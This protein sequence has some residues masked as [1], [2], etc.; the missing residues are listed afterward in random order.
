MTAISVLIPTF[1]YVCVDLVRSL[2]QQLQR[3]DADYE[4]I[5]ADDGSTNHD[6]VV[7]NRAIHGMEHC[8]YV[9]RQQ[10][11]GR[12]AIRNFLASESQFPL[13]LF[14]DSDMVVTRDDFMEAYLKE[15]DAQVVD[16]GVQIRG[17]EQRNKHNLRFIYEKKS[18]ELHNAD[19]RQRN[20][21]RDFHTA[22]FMVHRD[23]MTA[24]PFDLRFRHYGYE[25]V[26]FGKTM[27][28]N[29][30]VIRHIDNPLSFEVFETNSE[31]VE[32]TEEGMRT[33]H[34]FQEELRGYNHLLTMAGV[35]KRGMMS[36]LIRCWHRLFGPLIRRNL[37]G[38][39]PC[40]RLFN[41]YKLGYFLSLQ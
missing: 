20:P 25:D 9:E 13:L 7:A 6:T 4:I 12:A 14:I 15:A 24:H 36:P 18:E 35:L 2:H 28:Q 5:V 8:R 1:N 39:R 21:Y 37:T 17:D 27:R 11:V 30:I 29:G 23:V 31:F 34:Q 22:N 33:L 26:L 41:V 10:N 32:K 40:L 3:L 38:N 19:A 16:G